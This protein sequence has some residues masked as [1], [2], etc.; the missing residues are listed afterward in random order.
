M[1]IS[2]ISD[3]FSSLGLSGRGGKCD[4]ASAKRAVISSGVIF[5]VSKNS[6]GPQM[7]DTL[8]AVKYVVHG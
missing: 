7:R 3:R 8:V 5:L 6:C 4:A 1:R 2:L